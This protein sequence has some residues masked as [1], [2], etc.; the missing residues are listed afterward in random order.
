M[1]SCQ[2]ISEGNI[3]FPKSSLYPFKA[4]NLEENKKS[5]KLMVILK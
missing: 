4:D 3:R 1:D 2:K 5:W